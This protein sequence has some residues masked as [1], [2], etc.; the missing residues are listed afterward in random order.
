MLC[1]VFCGPARS[2]TLDLDQVL[3]PIGSSYHLY[4]ISQI[5][6]WDTLQGTGVV[7]DYAWTQVDSIADKAISMIPVS[8]APNA[9]AYPDAD[10]VERSITGQNY[11]I[12]RFFDVRSDQLRELGSVGPVLSY[13][14]D[15]PEV[16]YTYPMQLGDTSFGAYCVWSDGLGSQ[17]HFCGDSYTTFDAMGTLILPYGTFSDVKHVTRW[18]QSVET[19]MPDGDTTIVVRQQWFLPDVHFPVLDVVLFLYTDGFV[20]PSGWLMDGAITTSVREREA[21][22]EWSISPVPTV[23]PVTVLMEL[24]DPASLEI[25]ALDGRVVGSHLL[26][27]GITRHHLSLNGLPDGTYLVRMNSEGRISTRRI[28]KVSGD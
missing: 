16:L 23:G 13:A 7:W 27:P 4:S 19:T 6:P 21:V 8:A 10:Q 11:V 28:I 2:Q 5:F 14:F 26:Q 9:S 1:V 17:F 3:A 22:V 24:A 18:H 25:L 15:D 20:S 12:D